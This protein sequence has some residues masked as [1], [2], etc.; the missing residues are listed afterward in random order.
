MQPVK[1]SVLIVKGL[2]MPGLV[3]TWQKKDVGG[4][5]LRQGFAGLSRASPPKL[6]AGGQ[7]R[8]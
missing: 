6:S 7:A 4:R 1:L 2:V 8:P 5:D 3:H